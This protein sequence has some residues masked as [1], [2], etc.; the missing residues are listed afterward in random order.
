MLKAGVA[1]RAICLIKTVIALSA[2]DLIKENVVTQLSQAL[3]SILI[4]ILYNRYTRT[5]LKTG[6]S[7]DPQITAKIEG[8]QMDLLLGMQIPLSVR[9][10]LFEVLHRVHSSAAEELYILQS[11]KV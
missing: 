11:S 9:T 4:S 7:R 1:N 2:R 8:D 3:N 10:W 5:P 6:L